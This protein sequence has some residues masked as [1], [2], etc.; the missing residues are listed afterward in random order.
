MVERSLKKHFWSESAVLIVG[1]FLV[2]GAIL[3]LWGSRVDSQFSMVT[4][5]AIKVIF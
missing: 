2:A 3:L 1:Y 5:P 4:S